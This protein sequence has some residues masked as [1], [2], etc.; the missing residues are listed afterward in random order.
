MVVLDEATAYRLVT[1]AIE[2]VGGTRRIHGN[3]RHPFSF[4]ATR[5]VEVQGYTV[6][7]RY[8]EISS[9]AVAEVEGYVF[10][11]LA[12]EVVKLFGP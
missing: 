10:E 3:P 12:D 8:G 5:E 11:I 6:L 9:P 1:E 7:I 2:R 4:D